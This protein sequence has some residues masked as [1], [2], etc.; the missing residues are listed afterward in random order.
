MP[1][2]ILTTEGALQLATLRQNLQPAARRGL[3]ATVG[4]EAE[5]VYR[6]HFRQREA[7]SPNRRGWPRQHFWNRI[8]TSTAYDE[9]ATTDKTAKVVVSD[10]AL[11]PHVYGGPIRPKE[12]KLLAIPA[13]KEAYGIRPSSGLIPDLFFVETKKGAKMLASEV[14]G[15][16]VVYYWL[17]ESVTIPKDP[18][19]VPA[20]AAVEAALLKAAESFVTRRLPR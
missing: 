18:D 10:P 17:K 6:T 4:R 16:L 9:S 2:K 8:R 12:K 13:R 11:L 15:K 7:S 14:N 5:R 20:D 1:S 3:M 19:A